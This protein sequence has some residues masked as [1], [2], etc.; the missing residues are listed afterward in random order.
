MTPQLE[1]AIAAIQPLSPSERQQLI[2][3]LI[4]TPIQESSNAE[5]IRRLSDQF[6][7]GTSL[8]DLLA[9]QKPTTLKDL[10]S[11]AGEFWPEE[12]SIDEFLDFLKQQRQG[13]I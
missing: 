9:T 11:I 5:D 2:Q 8:N 10:I 7:Q 6:W 12:D 4:Q 13:F 1:N 3:V